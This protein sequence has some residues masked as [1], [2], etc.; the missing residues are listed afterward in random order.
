MDPA[1]DEWKRDGDGDQ[2]APHEQPVG[3]AALQAAPPDEGVQGDDD[4]QPTRSLTNA[5]HIEVNRLLRS[6]AAQ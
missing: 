3:Q 4:A 2:A 5:E 1:E 6:L